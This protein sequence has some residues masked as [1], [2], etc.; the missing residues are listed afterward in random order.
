MNFGWGS[1]WLGEI[2]RA[3]GTGMKLGFPKILVEGLLTRERSFALANNSL[4]SESEQ[5]DPARFKF[6]GFGEP[7]EE[8]R[9]DAFSKV[10]FGL[11]SYRLNQLEPV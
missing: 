2:F 3:I 5:I 6:R 7:V 1:K 11:N 10:Q 8:S 9:S 4:S